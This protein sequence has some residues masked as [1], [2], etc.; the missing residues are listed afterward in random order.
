MKL[1]LADQENVPVLV[2]TGDVPKEHGPV[3]RAGLKNLLYKGKDKIIVDLTGVTEIAPESVADIAALHGVAME[4]HGRIVL[5]TQ[6]KAIVEKVAGAPGPSLMPVVA[7]VKE[8]IGL[9]KASVASK[10]EEDSDEAKLLAIREKE[11]QQEVARMEDNVKQLEAKVAGSKSDELKALVYRRKWLES[12]VGILQR[13]LE[14]LPPPPAA[15]PEADV[16]V[17]KKLGR[18]EAVIQS[19]MQEK[20]GGK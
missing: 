3:L 6:N 5:V 17:K 16:A 2:V 12:S 14:K 10:N 1:K 19:L 8:A 15:P 18:V 13:M 20:A 7:S 11:L 4:L 9:L